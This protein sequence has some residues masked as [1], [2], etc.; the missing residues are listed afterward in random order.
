MLGVIGVGRASLENQVVAGALPFCTH[1]LG[2]EPNQR[3]EPIDG[4]GKLREELREAVV[5]FDVGEF[6]EE[7]NLAAL[8]G[9]LC[10]VCGEQDLG[11][12]NAPSHGH[13]ATAAGKECDVA[14]KLERSGDT[15]KQCAPGGV[16]D[17]LGRASQAPEHEPARKQG[18]K[19]KK[20]TEGPKK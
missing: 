18:E 12:E 10:G 16:D 14:T 3:V 9:P 6:M 5:A 11:T 17:G 13:G 15:R 8:L 2:G 4:A 1:P 7:N 20:N 19:S